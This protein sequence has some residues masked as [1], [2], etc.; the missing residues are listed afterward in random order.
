MKK[1]QVGY[2]AESDYR[3]GGQPAG[4][5]DV[6]YFQRYDYFMGKKKPEGVLDC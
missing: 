5:Q 2:F 3:K 4:F 6:I 1:T